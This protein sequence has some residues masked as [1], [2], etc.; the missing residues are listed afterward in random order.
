VQRPRLPSALLVVLLV[1]ALGGCTAL[2]GG[3]PP[4][5]TVENRDDATYRV[6]AYAVPDVEHPTDVTFRATTADGDRRSVDAAALQSGAAYRNVT[7]VDE[8]RSQQFTVPPNGNASATIDVWNGS[9]ATVYVVETIDGNESLVGGEVV[10]CERGG[11]EHRLTVV[12]G[13]KKRTSSTC[14]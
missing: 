4:T 14:A 9:T 1:A 6:T 13:A 2:S 10:T 11:Q 8:A 7:V 5:A 12:D 3:G